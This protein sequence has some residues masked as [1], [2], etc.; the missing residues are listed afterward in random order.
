MIRR[1]LQKL[2]NLLRA[3]EYR[4]ASQLADALGVS[5]KTVR[6]RIKDLNE[7]LEKY[8]AV[9]ES[10]AR[11][12]YRLVIKDQ[13]QFEQ[14]EKEEMAE[15]EEYIPDN[16]KE[17][18]EYLLAYLVWHRDYIKAEELCDFLYISRTT[19]TKAIRDV[20]GILKRYDLEIERKP[21]YGMKIKGR[22][23]D[24]RRLVCDY[25]IR[26]EYGVKLVGERAEKQLVELAG[27]IRT[28]LVKYE[29][30]ISETAFENFVEYVF[31]ACKR[32]CRDN[33]LKIAMDDIPETG[34]R[35]KTFT[36]ELSEYLGKKYKCIVTKEEKSYILLYLSGKR[37]VGNI[38]EN[39]NN[40]VIREQLDRM[41][42]SM[43]EYIAK[44]YHMD[45]RNDFDIRMTL[46]Q[47]LVPLDIRM[48]FDIPIHNPML[49]DIKT[50]YSLAY[51]ISCETA[52][53][54]REHYKKEVSED[55]SGY[56]ALIFELAIEKGQR[57]EKSDI[58]VVCSTGKSSSRLL[59]YKYE[60]Q[61]ADYL[62]HIY[63]CDLIGLEQFDFSKVNYVFTTVPIMKEIPVPIVE[64]GMFLGK[65]DVQ[66]VTEI[67]KKG[68]G[69]Y[70]KEYYRPERFFSHVK[71]ETKE[72]IL[73]FLCKKIEEREQVDPDFYEMV[74]ERESY[75]QMDY[76]NLIAIPHP[77]RI[78]SEKTFAYVA[79]LEHPVMWNQKEAQVI[80]LTS[81]GRRE[82]KN[83]QKFYDATAKFA[84]SGAAVKGLIE[85]PEYE[86]LMQYMNME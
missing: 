57:G 25:F 82:D 76:G 45:F 79:I 84:L 13:K 51:Q 71:G 55:E 9:I 52:Q 4:T 30:P 73:E 39:D 68:A 63:V 64:V 77:N 11:F 37:I 44:E 6:L 3:D 47:H 59:K 69:G 12:G 49:E 14:M 50:N 53:I 75:I 20:E 1:E 85:K 74:L 32:M 42:L 40:F 27:C 83:R 24:I 43:L 2:M 54:L 33:Y 67:L 5:E 28:M 58:L 10:K 19:L 35:E 7:D 18:S 72:E 65:E 46:N 8:G 81:V 16:G 38:V 17:R 61:F 23:L 62:N 34:I 56:L 22:E 36:N 29:I 41:A 26:R 15:P 21:N 80:I 60:Q 31:V 78:A 86:T 66:K 48:R 70:L